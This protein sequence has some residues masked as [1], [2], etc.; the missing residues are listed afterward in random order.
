M[1]TTRSEK[2][3]VIKSKARR[4]LPRNSAKIPENEGGGKH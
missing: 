4:G 3:A 2:G 1:M